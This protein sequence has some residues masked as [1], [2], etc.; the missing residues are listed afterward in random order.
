MVSAAFG[1]ARQ[2]A[3]R[4]DRSGAIE[5]LD[6]VPLTS[7][8][9][10]EAQLTSVLMLLDCRPMAEI[11]EADLRDAARRV[12]HLAE[13]EPR[14]LQMRA[15]VFGTALDWLGPARRPPPI[16][17]SA[18]RSTNRVCAPGSRRYFG[19]WRGIRRDGAIVTPW[20]TFRIRSDRRAGRE[21]T[22]RRFGG[23]ASEAAALAACVG[24]IGNRTDG[25]GER[26]DA[27]TGHA[28]FR[29]RAEPRRT[30]GA[31]D[32]ALTSQLSRAAA[33]ARS[34]ARL[35]SSGWTPGTAAM[36]PLDSRISGAPA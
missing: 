23:L 4:D 26:A 18:N 27:G 5:V 30:A 25:P 35:T 2:L 7:R 17:S 29:G 12:E 6:Q 21:P 1:L 9:Y 33:A 32:R 16:R 3:F 24:R 22:R 20:S 13:G 31:P 11:T 36:A 19:S 10:G 28:L 34:A 15:L 14:A 8:H